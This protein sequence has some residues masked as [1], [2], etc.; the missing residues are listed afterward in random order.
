MTASLRNID[1]TET[2]FKILLHKA[3][4]L[5]DNFSAANHQKTAEIS[6]LKLETAELRVENKGLRQS[7][8]HLQ[9][10]LRMIKATLSSF[11]TESSQQVPTS[12]IDGSSVTAGPIQSS[13]NH[14]ETSNN[15][16][17]SD[18]SAQGGATSRIV[19]PLRDESFEV[20]NLATTPSD[21]KQNIVSGCPVEKSNSKLKSEQTPQRRSARNQ[22]RPASYVP[23]WPELNHIYNKRCASPT[24]SAPNKRQKPTQYQRPSAEDIDDESPHSNYMLIHGAGVLESASQSVPMSGNQTYWFTDDER[25]YSAKKDGNGENAPGKPPLSS[26]S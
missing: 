16:S 18:I 26:L 22:R 20:P 2:D 11:N 19:E 1:S 14:D 5:A 23:S 6:T 10:K 8:E 25:A 15:P 24:S 9:S 12:S 21:F 4:E 17:V 13:L 7:N 3:S